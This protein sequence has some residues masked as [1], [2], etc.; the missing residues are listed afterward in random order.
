MRI[1]SIV[2][3][4]T[5]SLL[6]IASCTSNKKK[7]KVISGQI[8]AFS[9]YMFRCNKHDNKYSWHCIANTF[10]FDKNSLI[11]LKTDSNYKWRISKSTLNI[12]QIDSINNYIEKLKFNS[13]IGNNSVLSLFNA[14]VP[15]CGFDFGFIDSIGIP[16]IYVPHNEIEY[17]EN[18]SNNFFKYLYNIKGITTIYTNEIIS[19]Y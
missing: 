11:I 10:L 17:T 8:K 15:Y 19:I 16:E 14:H 6:S 5:I 4:I 3:I 7:E 9:A 18:L 1:I 12:N 13:L 2:I